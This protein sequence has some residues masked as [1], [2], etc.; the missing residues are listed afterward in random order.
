[1]C[2]KPSGTHDAISE[3][4]DFSFFLIFGY[5]G[6]PYCFCRPFLPFFGGHGSLKR[7]I[8]IC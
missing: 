8:L 7:P 4:Q 1:M 6:T 3:F 2:I 5:F